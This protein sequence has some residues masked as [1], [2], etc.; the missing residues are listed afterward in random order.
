MRTTNE[1]NSVGVNTRRS[2]IISI[3]PL[4]EL[5]KKIRSS[6]ATQNSRTWI[7]WKC[8]FL[9]CRRKLKAREFEMIRS[10]KTR[11]TPGLQ[12]PMF[13]HNWEGSTFSTTPDSGI[14]STL[15]LESKFSFIMH[16]THCLLIFFSGFKN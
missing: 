2:R 5:L 9:G 4:M 10:T 8:N 11:R 7:F 1:S 12:R 16:S 6:R 15:L 14:L 13:G 3:F